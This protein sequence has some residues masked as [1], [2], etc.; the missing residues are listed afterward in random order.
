MKGVNMFSSARFSL[1]ALALLGAVALAGCTVAADEGLNIA[2]DQS[3][4]SA[5]IDAARAGHPAA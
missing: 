3:A 4:Y 1:R 5:H 2:R